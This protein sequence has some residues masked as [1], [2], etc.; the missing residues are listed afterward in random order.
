MLSEQQKR[1]ADLYITSGNATQ[2][3]IEAGY[4]ARGNAA[5]V[6]A[7]RLLRNVKVVEY[8]EQRN[9]QLE[10]SRIA[11]MEEVKQFWS[12]TMRN[13]NHD[14]KDRLKAS[15]YI[16]KTNAAFLDKVQHSGGTESK[17]TVVFD[18]GLDDE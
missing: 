15:E 1:F 8:I 14:L 6:S 12:E 7:C 2:S 10:N 17:L 16:A 18:P 5:E 11:C 9:K 13:R 3:Y 4:K